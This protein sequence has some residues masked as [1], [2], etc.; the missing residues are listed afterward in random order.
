VGGEALIAELEQRAPEL[1][2]RVR[3]LNAAIGGY[4][5]PQQLVALVLL[6]LQG[7]RFDAIVNLDGFNEIALSSTD[8]TQRY[9]PLYPSRHHYLLELELGREDRSAETIERY[10]EVIRSRRSAE[11]WRAAAQRWPFGGS[12]L[13]RAL[14]GRAVL[15]LESRAARLGQELQEEASP[16]PGLAAYEPAC[17]RDPDGCWD[18][19]ADIWEKSSLEMAAIADRIGARYLHVLQP[20]Q[21]DQGSK[22]LSDVERRIAYNPEHRWAAGVLRGYPILRARIPGM[23]ARGVAVH[24]FTRLFADVAEDRYVDVC[25]H[26]NLRGTN[27]LATAIAAAML[28]PKR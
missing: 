6:S 24:D 11:A 19:I 27:A 9:N 21:Y 16:P 26:Y 10:A 2:G 14:F 15:H 1:R 23:R 17:L 5:Q 20:N 28:E 12:E 18:L 22:P 8:A 13:V 4:K 3:I 7:V 25:C